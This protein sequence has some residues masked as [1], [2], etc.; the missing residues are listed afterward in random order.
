MATFFVL[1]DFK[2]DFF[3]VFIGIGISIFLIIKKLN[4]ISS[5]LLGTLLGAFISTNSLQEVLDI[6]VTG[7]SNMS[8]INARVIS[9]GIMAGVLIG[10]GAMEKIA[11]WII[12]ILGEQRA[13]TALALSAMLST[14]F[15]VFITVGVII[16]GPI[17]MEM[18]KKSNISK[19]SIILALS[20][21]GKAGNIISPNP[22]TVAASEIFELPLSYVMLNGI[23][24][25]ILGI[26]FTIIIA[27]KLKNKKDNIEQIDEEIKKL[28]KN[29]LPSILKSLSAP[30]IALFLLSFGPI[31]NIFIDIPFLII[32]I[33]F[34]LPISAIIGVIILGK[35]REI[36]SYINLGISKV[37]PVILTMMGVGALGE[38]IHRSNLPN[39]I[40]NVIYTLN[41]PIFL[42][43]PISG[44]FMSLATGSTS[45]GVILA[46][47]SFA[48]TLIYNGI[49][50]ISAA[51]MMHAGSMFLDTTP[52]GNYIL[53][54]CEVFKIT[55]KER[56]KIIPYEIIV[57]GIIMIAAILI[58]QI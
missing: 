24:P 4:P 36:I 31:L 16:L 35:T 10:S 43:A 46:G 47:S 54:S 30:L 49:A 11:R 41:I 28:E 15:G 1:G 13:V 39:I 26:T 17:G 19:S 34:I 21:G 48:N 32:D 27:N 51:I 58:M 25:A 5:L 42:L 7:I 3:A 18:Y 9:G 2:L 20:G 45:N 33:M 44:A 56:I 37:M 22:N 8:G 29:K 38:M 6:F 12:D 53:A 40:E 55:M 23:I 50:P 14:A 52:H 57:G